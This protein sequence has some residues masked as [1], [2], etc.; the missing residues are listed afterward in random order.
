MKVF[1]IFGTIEFVDGNAYVHDVKMADFMEEDEIERGANKYG[2]DYLMPH[3]YDGQIIFN[4]YHKERQ[5][6]AK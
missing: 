3:Y 6:E 4:K 5:N 2:L 1:A